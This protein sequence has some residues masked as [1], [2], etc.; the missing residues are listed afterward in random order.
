M[1]SEGCGTTLGLK[2]I[3]SGPGGPVTSI[4][5]TSFSECS[6]ITE[7]LA[8]LTK[9]DGILV[10]DPKGLAGVDAARVEVKTRM[11]QELGRG[12]A[13]KG[14]TIRATRHIIDAI[15]VGTT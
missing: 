3:S 14:T 1:F 9:V 6:L 7:T 15:K 13:A 4:T 8:L 2:T 5:S 12:V 11:F 10:N